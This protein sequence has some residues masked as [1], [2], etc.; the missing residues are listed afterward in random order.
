MQ[1]QDYIAENQKPPSIDDLVRKI[2]EISTL[3]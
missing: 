1:L 2:G 3:P